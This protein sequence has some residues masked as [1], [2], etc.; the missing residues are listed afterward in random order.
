MTIK[1]KQ[2][3]LCYLGYYDGDIDGIWNIDSDMATKLFQKDFGL[4]PNGTV[5]SKTEKALKH[6]IT[7]GVPQLER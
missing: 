5:D 6:A 2:C 3:L 7:Y 1:Q 4:I